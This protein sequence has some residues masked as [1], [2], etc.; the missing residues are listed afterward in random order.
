MARMPSII[1]APTAAAITEAVEELQALDG[2]REDS[3]EWAGGVRSANNTERE[4]ILEIERAARAKVAEVLALLE[5][6]GY[7]TRR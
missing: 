1:P 2:A 6:Q 5:A 4:E 7:V 3:L